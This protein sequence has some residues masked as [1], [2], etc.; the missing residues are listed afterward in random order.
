MP[1][2]GRARG[3]RARGGLARGAKSRPSKGVSIS[4]VSRGTKGGGRGRG[5][6]GGRDEA[7][8]RGTTDEPPNEQ[9]EGNADD[10][11]A[12]E[13]EGEDDAF[14]DTVGD[15]T[16]ASGDPTKD[17]GDPKPSHGLRGR[18][19]Y[20]HPL[21]LATRIG[22]FGE[23]A[24]TLGYGRVVSDRQ[25]QILDAGDKLWKLATNSGHWREM[26]DGGD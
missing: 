22:P 24:L 19:P 4:G 8:T 18:R 17:E 5:T 20:R 16:E 10:S 26:L 13:C 15:E 3:G 23:F 25:R 7:A 6:E 1:R 2:G 21:E 14:R 9:R 12:C 11:E